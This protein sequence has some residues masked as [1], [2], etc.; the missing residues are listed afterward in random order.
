MDPGKEIRNTIK[1]CIHD[2]KSEATIN[3]RPRPPYSDQKITDLY[4]QGFD[5]IALL[6]SFRYPV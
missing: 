6:I 3:P 4:H 5:I 2:Y 1:G